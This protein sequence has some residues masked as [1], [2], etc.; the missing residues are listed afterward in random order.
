MSLI[1]PRF[2]V[3]VHLT[4]LLARLEK[5]GC[6][7]CLPSSRIAQALDIHPVVVRRMIALLIEAELVACQ[8][9]KTGGAR[10]A[11]PPSRI[12]LWDIHEAVE[13]EP[14]IVGKRPRHEQSACP[15]GQSLDTLLTPEITAARAALERILSRTSLAK[16]LSRLG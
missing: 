8:H 11:R 14:S 7:S 6:T 16:V 15:V 1:N 4:L 2:P 10:L 12:S 9:G 3:A 5:E 13:P